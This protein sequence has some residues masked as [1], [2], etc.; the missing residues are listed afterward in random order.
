MA[1]PSVTPAK[2]ITDPKLLQPYFAGDSWATWRAI[3]KAAAAE[4]LLD[5]QLALFRAVAGD[6]AAPRRPV[7]HA[8]VLWSLRS[9]AGVRM[10]GDRGPFHSVT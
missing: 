7:H 6:R 8:T 1:T 4:P 9:E 3:L 2:V 5:D 10:Y